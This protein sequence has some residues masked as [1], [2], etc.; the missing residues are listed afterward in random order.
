MG[1]ALESALRRDR[2]GQSLIEAALI[3]PLLIML[4]F[5]AINVGYFFC[6]CLNLTTASR[7]GVGYS[8]SGTSSVLQ[9]AVPSAS[10]VS[11][12][13]YENLTGT[14]P[15]AVHTPIRVCT[16]ALGLTGSGS[17]QIPNCAS[18]GA[19]PGTFASLQP[20]PEAPYLLLHSVDVEYAPT[21]L[22]P[23]SAFNLFGS[24]LV[25]HRTTIMRA[26]P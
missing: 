23:G 11:S 22:I 25:F 12:L 6:V 20:D 8:A 26:M 13:V 7:M 14:L 24:S 9:A 21:P 18:Y 2:T 5:N 3:L 19:H 15:S 1:E 4:A 17:S 16:L 10:T